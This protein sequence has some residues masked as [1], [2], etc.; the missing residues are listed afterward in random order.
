LLLK[1][2]EVSPFRDRFD[3]Y[4]GGQRGDAKIVLIMLEAE[5]S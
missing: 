2:L 3:F 5:F 1:A 4:D